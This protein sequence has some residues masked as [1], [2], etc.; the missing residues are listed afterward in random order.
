MGDGG[1]VLAD[2]PDAHAVGVAIEEAE[3][4]VVVAVEHGVLDVTLGDRNLCCM[5]PDQ[6]AA[7]PWSPR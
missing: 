4:L 3:V 1:H 6:S 2:A 7:C 5:P